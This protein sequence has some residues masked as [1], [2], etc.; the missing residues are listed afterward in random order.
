MIARRPAQDR[1]PE[2]GRGATGHEV[3]PAGSSASPAGP[4]LMPRPAAPRT[5]CILL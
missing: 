5:R 2:A 1:G 4:A 3:I